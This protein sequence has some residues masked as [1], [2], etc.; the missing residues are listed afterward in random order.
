MLEYAFAKLNLTL[1][2]GE[3]RPDGYHD[4]RSVMT[5]C[6][7]HDT[8]T[9]EKAESISMTCDDQSL[10]CDGSNLCVRAAEVFFSD[11]AIRGG[12]TIHLKKVIPMQA[13]LGG[14]SADAAAML[15]ALRKLYAPHL[16]D[17]DLEQ[18]AEKLGSDVPFCVKSKTA[19]C[20]GRG[21]KMQVLRRLPSLWYVIVKPEAAYAT[22][23]MYAALD[24]C[25]AQRERTTDAMLEAVRA[26]KKKAVYTAV[27]NDFHL[28]LPEDSPVPGIRAKLWELGA[29]AAAMSGSGSAVFGIYDNFYKGRCAAMLMEEL[30]YK[31]FFAK[32]V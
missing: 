5:C 29:K 11:N 12:C 4:L 17:A 10:T 6:D 15:R 20:Q 14:G 28:A 26:K 30:G 19:L 25:T 16:T 27:N 7:L 18:T 3:K 23:A 31:T 22:G 8:L 32:G 9:V 21:E 13:G 1:E 2:I 24:E